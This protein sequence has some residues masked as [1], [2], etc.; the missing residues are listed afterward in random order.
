LLDFLNHTKTYS[1]KARLESWIKAPLVRI[2]KIN[3]RLDSVE[4]LMAFSA[5]TNVMRKKL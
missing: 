1:G 2:S 5:E 4:D 3:S